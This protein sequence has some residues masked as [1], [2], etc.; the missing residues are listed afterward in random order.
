MNL[1]KLEDLLHACVALALG[2]GLLVAVVPHARADAGEDW[3]AYRVAHGLAVDPKPSLPGELP[4][5]GGPVPDT[6]AVPLPDAVAANGNGNG[7]G[8]GATR[9]ELLV[10][11]AKSDGDTRGE[12][13]ECN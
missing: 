8:H 4:V 3:V 10:E 6:L 2:V 12:D 1:E 5:G 11:L 7:N 13:V 9:C